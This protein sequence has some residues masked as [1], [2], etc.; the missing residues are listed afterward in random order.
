[1]RICSTWPRKMVCVPGTSDFTP[2]Q[3]NDP[4]ASISP[5]GPV[6]RRVQ[7]FVLKRFSPLCPPLNVV[8][9]SQSSARSTFTQNTLL[10]AT[11]PCVV[12]SLLMQASTV[13]GSALAEHTAVARSEEHT[14]ELQSHVNLVC[15]L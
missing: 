6:A 11:V 13:G 9:R 12:A 15:R 7:S 3:S 1:M 4:S 8:E 5:G 2:R 10:F 14:S